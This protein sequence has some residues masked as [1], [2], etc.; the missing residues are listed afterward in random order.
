MAK[1]STG[2]PKNFDSTMPIVRNPESEARQLAMS[3][4]PSKNMRIA[5]NFRRVMGGGWLDLSDGPGAGG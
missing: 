1:K 5:S 3:K 2:F 4:A